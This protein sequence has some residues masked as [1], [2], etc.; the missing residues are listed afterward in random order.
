VTVTGEPLR[1]AIG[2]SSWV[3][4]I[5]AQSQSLKQITSILTLPPIQDSIQQSNPNKKTLASDFQF[6]DDFTP[7]KRNT[8]EKRESKDK[9]KSD[10]SAD[11]S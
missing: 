1:L 11:S 3:C 4:R 10:D 9:K 5:D 2:K 6:T 8:S 7:K